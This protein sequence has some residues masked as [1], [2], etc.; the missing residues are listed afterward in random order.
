MAKGKDACPMLS[1]Q[2]LPRAWV[3]PQIVM[4]NLKAGDTLLSRLPSNS[5]IKIVLAFGRNP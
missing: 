4:G 5:S 1:S 2:P 3:R